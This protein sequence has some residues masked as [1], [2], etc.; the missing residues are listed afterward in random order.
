M[1]NML[2]L[3]MFGDNIEDVVGHFFF[4]SCYLLSGVVGALTYASL[5]PDSTMPLIGASGALSGIVGMYMIFFPKVSAEIIF[6]FFYWEIYRVQTTTLSAIG[7]WFGLQVILGLTIEA[8]SLG[9]YIKVAFSAHVGGFATG[10]LL[11]VLFRQSGYVK[12]YFHNGK[13]HWLLGYIY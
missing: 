4:L 6:L 9:E 13:K 11:G 5:H 1:G 12:R 2:F 10:A 7:F 8:T 3:W